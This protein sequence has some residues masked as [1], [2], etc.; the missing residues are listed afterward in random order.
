MKQVSAVLVCGCY[1]YFALAGRH[2]ARGATNMRRGHIAAVATHSRE[3]RSANNTVVSWANNS[4]VLPCGGKLGKMIYLGMQREYYTFHPCGSQKARA[5]LIT[6]HCLG[7]TP[8][9]AWD[10]YLK[11]AERHGFIVI[12]PQGF[13]A[14][15][16]AAPYCCGHAREIGLDDQGFI[17]S[18]TSLVDE[19]RGLPVFATGVSNGGY[20]ASS[21]AV[22]FPGW[23]TGVVAAAGHIYHGLFSG[24]HGTAAMILWDEKDTVVPP[25]G[26]CR[27]A[28]MPH[29][30]C[31]ISEL[32]PPH[33]TSSQEIFL[34]WKRANGC[35][36]VQSYQGLAGITGTCQSGVGCKHPTEL[37]TFRKWIHQEWTLFPEILSG[38]VFNFFLAQLNNEA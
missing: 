8:G 4:G 18:L 35:K 28:S 32:G 36:A 1:L 9:H 21:L 33:C 24:L 7:C 31:G 5:I 26:C 15:F 34:A 25:S 27:D 6:I 29:C 17:K 14:S 13:N 16:N 2:F 38:K 19:G 11:D 23:L 3:I 10:P 12:A 20:M 22:A 30:C 37:C